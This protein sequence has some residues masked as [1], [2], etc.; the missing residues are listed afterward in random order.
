MREIE[1]GRGRGEKRVG[2]EKDRHKNPTN[3]V[4]LFIAGICC[5]FTHF[6]SWIT[7]TD[8]S[9][10]YLTWNCYLSIVVK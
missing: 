2:V 5:H 7:V 9:K 3:I 4:L 6:P 10:T 1:R 8:F